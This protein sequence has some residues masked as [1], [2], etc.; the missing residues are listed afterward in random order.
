MRT[1]FFT[2]ATLCG[3]FITTAAAAQEVT[4]KVTHTYPAN[5]YLIE[6][7]LQILMDRVTQGTDGQV[8][9]EV[10]PAGQL[11]RDHLGNLSSG[12]AH[13]AL[14]SPSA[15]SNALVLSTVGELPG[16]YSTA[17]EGS[18][19]TAALMQ[20]GGVLDTNELSGRGIHFLY[21][22]SLSQYPVFSGPKPFNSIE[23]LAGM[24]I[25]AGG[26]A[27]SKSFRLLD[28][29]PIQ[30]PG[31]E[32]F[33]SLKRGTVD[34]AF[35]PAV[36]VPTYNLEEVMSSAITGTDMG[37][38]TNFVGISAA[39]WDG[40]SDEQ[41]QIF[42]E[43][44]AEAQEKFCAWI[45]EASDDVID[46]MVNEHGMELT[47]LTDEQRIALLEHLAPVREE[48]VAEMEA[49]RKDG[50]AVLDAWEAARTE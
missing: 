41:K 20:D 3:A 28:A 21:A 37:G 27:I 33:D 46:N 17:C 11:G 44:A 32:M 39:A 5:H 26:A 31:S 10:Y 14:M 45:D 36:G 18:A 43:A 22:A 42:T 34:G 38:A 9:F 6:H 19:L 47:V 50:R 30:I 12:L 29:V 1:A 49:A 35:F 13:I 15:E 23:D 48:W 2:A 7:G 24:K 25:R 4:L 16:A 40:L 8:K